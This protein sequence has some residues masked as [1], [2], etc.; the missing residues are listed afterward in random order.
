MKRKITLIIC[1]LLLVGA[2]SAY[3]QARLDINV[4]V[5]FYLGVELGSFGEGEGASIPFF[6]PFPDFGLYYQFDLGL[7]K[8]GAGARVFTFILVNLAY[9]A[10]FA[11][12]DLNPIF[13]NVNLGG[14]TYLIFGALETTMADGIAL[15]PDIFVGMRF[16]DWFGLGAG[17]FFLT[18]TENFMEDNIY[19]FYIRANFKLLF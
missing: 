4:S 6:I 15:C 18:N 9:P 3:S 7:I 8:L 1:C 12:I 19:A 10:F 2:V 16:N 14:L 13:I 17:A 11:E 5:P